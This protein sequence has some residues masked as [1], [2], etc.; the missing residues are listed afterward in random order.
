MARWTA[1]VYG[2]TGYLGGELM[3]RLLLHPQVELVAAF[4]ADHLGEPLAA[5]QPHLEGWSSLRYQPIDDELTAAPADI[6]FLALPHA[7]SW[8]VV[9]A[10]EPTGARIIDCSGAFRV[11]DAQAYERLYGAPHPLPHLLER[12][13]YGLTEL[14]RERI[15][16]SRFV[17]SPGC[18]ATTITLGLAP[19]ARAGLLQGN[20]HTTG[21]T[22]SSGSG[23]VATLTTHHP[24]RAGNLKTYKPLQ[25]PHAAEVNQTLERLGGERVAVQF[26]PVSAPLVRGIFATSFAEVALPSSDKRPWDEASLAALVADCFTSSRFVRQPAARLPEVVA[27]AGSNYAEVK[28]VPGPIVDESR[29]LVTCFSALDNLVKGGAGQAIQNL[30]VMLGLDESCALL[31][32]GGYP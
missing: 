30:N 5:A 28:L 13:V 17:A 29:Q 25:H 19:L 20:V 23:S 9:E 7:V 21:I 31:D 3:R 32:P 16:S 8:R 12:F 11:E 18:F 27:V 24:V 14:N 2:A 4:A 1:A 15:A 10:L 26:V 6:L 22:G